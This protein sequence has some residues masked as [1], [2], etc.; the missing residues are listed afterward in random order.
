MCKYTVQGTCL[1]TG[2]VI[3]MKPVHVASCGQVSSGPIV[4]G[5]D[6]IRPGEEGGDR[7]LERRG[8]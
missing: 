1:L 2:Q 5:G 4:A 7:Q 8:Q 6:N 3:M